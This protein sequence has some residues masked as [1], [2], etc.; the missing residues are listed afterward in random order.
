M[1]LEGHQAMSLGILMPDEQEA[2][3]LSR[4]ITAVPGRNPSHL[5]ALHKLDRAAVARSLRTGNERIQALDL[6]DHP[7]SSRDASAR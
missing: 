7:C 4:S 6:A 1:R 2:Q 3:M 5:A